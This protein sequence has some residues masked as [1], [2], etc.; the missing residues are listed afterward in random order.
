MWAQVFPAAPNIKILV[1][2][3]IVA[4]FV[5]TLIRHKKHG[6]LL[7]GALLVVASFSFYRRHGQDETMSAIP[8]ESAEME[9]PRI[10]ALAS[11]EAIPEVST[12]DFDEETDQIPL[13]LP[14]WVTD[15]PEKI[16]GNRCMLVSSGP[17]ATLDE[18]ARKLSSEIRKS[19]ER[20]VHEHM[21][22]NLPL[23]DLRQSRLRVEGHE[24]DEAR[25]FAGLG[26]MHTR[27]VLV[28]FDKKFHAYV[29]RSHMRQ[30][31]R[32]RLKVAGGSFA[33]LMI[34]VVGCFAVLKSKVARAKTSHEAI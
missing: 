25:E 34:A 26:L 23:D 19:A 9:S 20:Y 12:E 10:H 13:E 24:Y 6:L 3:V 27:H 18:S 2:F 33:G 7:L 32:Q 11:D 14:K 22:I 17:Y 15:P 29:E 8:A 16:N 5:A 28:Q 1:L 4:I 31:I 30:E 21:H